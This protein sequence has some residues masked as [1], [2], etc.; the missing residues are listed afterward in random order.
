MV[1]LAGHQPVAALEPHVAELA[2]F[3]LSSVV[4]PGRGGREVQAEE[5]LCP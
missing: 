5:V 4:Q 2:S 1:A 3:F